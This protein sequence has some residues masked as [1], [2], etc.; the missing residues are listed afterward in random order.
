[1]RA[2]WQ[3]L[4]KLEE[5][6]ARLLAWGV[7]DGAFTPDEVMEL[8]REFAATLPEYI[9]GEALVEELLDQRLLVRLRVHGRDLVRTRMAETVRLFARLRQLFPKR[10][11]R[12]APTLVADYR[13]ALRPRRY[14][15]RNRPLSE[16]LAELRA[17]GIAPTD[18]QGAAL[19][20]LATHD[21]TLR[22][23]AGFQLRAAARVWRDLHERRSRG[24]IVGAGTGTGKTLAFYL[25]ALAHLAGLVRRDSFWTKAIALYPRNELLKDQFAET[26]AQARKLDRVLGGA[27]GR[28]LRI[29]AFF[30]PTPYS[31]AERH[32][33]R[34]WTREGDAYVCPFLRCPG[35]GKTLFWR[36]GELRAGVERLRCA[37]AACGAVV[38][39]DE[40]VITR[41]RMTREPPDVLFTTTEMLNLRITDAETRHVFGIGTDR[42]PRIVL[43]DEVHTYAGIHGAQVA[44]VLRRWRQAIG[45]VA[46]QFT[47]LS[48]TLPNATEFFAQLVGLPAGAVA[49]VEPLPGE[50]EAEGMEYLLALRGDPASGTALLSTTIQGAMLLRRALDV[51]REQPS[52]RAAGTRVFVFADD[53]DVANRLYHNLLDAEGLTGGVRPRPRPGVEPLAALRAHRALPAHAETDPGE[54][55][56]AGQSWYLAEQIGHALAP[57]R[58]LRVGRTTSQDAGVGQDLDVVVATASLEVGYNDP[59]VGAVIQHKAPY[60]VAAFLQRKGR[61]GRDRKMRPWTVVVLSDYG[62]DRAAY[63]A[64]DQLFDPSVETRALPVGNRHV[65][66]MQAAFAVMDWVAG[67]APR[68]LPTGSVWQDFSAPVHR[69]DPRRR[70][71]GWEA[72]LIRGVLDGSEPLAQ[73]SLEDYL[74]AALQVTSDEARALLWEPPRALMTGVLPTLLR[75]LEAQWGDRSPVGDAGKEPWRSSRPLP[76]FVPENLFSDLNLPEVVVETPPDRNANPGEWPMPVL[77]AM[78]TLAPGRVT[79]RFAPFRARVSH[80]VPLPVLAAGE[81]ALPVSDFCPQFEELGPVQ[82]RDAAGGRQ[83]PCYRPWTIR[84]AEVPREVSVTSNAFLSWR[85]Q[86]SP[87]DEGERFEIPPGWESV[88]TEVR[89][90]VHA[91]HSHVQVRRFAVASNATIKLRYGAELDSRVSFVTPDGTGPACVGF[92]QESDG[93]VFRF[94]IPDGFRIGPDDPNGEKLRAFRAAYFRHR[95]MEDP[96]LSRHANVFAR[97]RL[98]Q[99]YLSALTAR[100]LVDGKG[101]AVA[102]TALRQEGLAAHLNRVLTIIFQ[103]MS[104]DDGG[105]AVV[106][107]ETPDEGDDEAGEEDPRTENEKDGDEPQDLQRV[108]RALRALAADERV[109]AALH[110]VAATLWTEPDEAWDTWAGE[111]FK[112][113]LG[114]ALLEACHRLCPQAGEGDFLLDLDAGPRPPDAPPPPDGMGEIWVTEATIGGGGL[115][116]ELL[117]RYAEDPRRFFLLARSALGPSDFE[118]VDTEL[119]RILELL[120][121]DVGARAAAAA[122]RNAPTHQ[123]LQRA[124]DAFRETLASRGILTTHPV[125]SAVHARVLRP[126]S[127]PASDAMLLDLVRSWRMA[128][129]DLGIDIDARVFAYVASATPH[130]DAAL[131]HVG[132]AYLA[133]P[134][135][136]FGTVYSLLWPRGGAVRARALSSYNPF[137][138]L[139]EAD[140]AVLLDL[141]HGTEAHVPLGEPGWRERLTEALATRGAAHLYAA[142]DRHAELRAAVLEAVA[143]PLDVEYLHLYPQVEGVER[144]GD[145]ISVRLHVREVL[146]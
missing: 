97:E 23:L 37:D 145:R 82:V 91:L 3:F 17:G 122:A 108:A 7:V 44:Y 93:M 5:L 32:V 86:L 135:W 38:Q 61:A 106:L 6:E 102:A 78:R 30:G 88:L 95:V 80:W 96:V 123:E 45:R 57:A 70:R 140:R 69:D 43:L 124:V 58:A 11:W 36:R 10:P 67:R 9:E 76:E 130:L 72:D 66:R 64:Y 137:A 15:E 60:E 4:G 144:T 42:P 110:Q 24:M 121:A 53:L 126:A 40:V 125:M 117:R 116:E 16:L 63:Q 1:V 146:P 133:D 14:P 46:V 127:S 29:G 85:T 109:V 34:A 26:Y 94:R 56:A 113:T 49:A 103:T 90:F 62:R 71:Q 99:V 50:M 84:A 25:P 74:A 114:G 118:I 92:M 33:E 136:R 12:A 139:P 129:A 138:S 13:F 98:A 41:E 35:C 105:M 68:H 19:R 128:E 22:D 73:Q 59:D 112:A 8:A 107:A 134:L 31:A 119:T 20:A 54:R 79:R 81:Q 52:S 132:R 143:S 65:L 104:P 87:S 101:L 2:A 115:V 77:R 141:L 47:G 75:R 83:L 28:K 21:G 18:V 131:A 48:A 100:A 142:P 111:R 120:E 27:G 55:L 39:P 51:T 89:F